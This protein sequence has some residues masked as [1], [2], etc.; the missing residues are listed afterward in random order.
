MNRTSFLTTM[1]AAALTGGNAPAQDQSVSP[2]QPG[3][4][5][6]KAAPP[7]FRH[8]VKTAAVTNAVVAVSPQQKEARAAFDKKLNDARAA[9]GKRDYSDAENALAQLVTD[10]SVGA[11]D[12]ARAKSVLVNSYQRQ[13]K[14]SEALK[15]NSEVLSEKA[16]AAKDRL[17]A[18]SVRIALLQRLD[19]FDEAA[20]TGFLLLAES[21]IKPDDALRFKKQIIDNYM[22]AGRLDYSIALNRELAGDASIALPER[23]NAFKGIADCHRKLGDLDQAIAVGNEA[24]ALP[25][26][27]DQK[28]AIRL[29]NAGFYMAMKP[30]KRAEADGILKGVLNDTSIAVTH[31]VSAYVAL[32]QPILGGGTKAEKKLVAELAKDIL[33]D[34]RITGDDFYRVQEQI[35]KAAKDLADTETLLAAASA[36]RARSDS[37]NTQKINATWVIVEHYMLTDRIAE[38][39]ELVREPLSYANLGPDDVITAYANIGRTLEWQEKCDEAVATY[40]EILTKANSGRAK[41]RVSQLIAGAL[42][43]FNRHEEAAQVYRDAGLPLEEAKVYR[44]SLTPEKAKPIALKV[45][46]NEQQPEDVRRQAY[47]FF[48]EPGKDDRQI[49][50]KHLAFYMKNFSPGANAGSFWSQARNAMMSANYE[51]ALRCLEIARTTTA[52]KDDFLAVLYQVNALA[53]L[54]RT[55]EAAKVAGDHA[56]SAKFTPEQRYQMALTAAM[57]QVGEQPGEIAKAFRAVEAASADARHLDSK[58]RAD[59]ILKVGRTAMIANRSVA[60]KEIYSVY[61]NLFV[62]EPKKLYTVTFSETPISGL[63]A[64]EHLRVQPVKQLLDRQF[65]GDMD[66]LVTDVA[67]GDRGAGIGS[68]GAAK[69]IRFTELAAICDVNGI[70]FVFTVYDDRAREVEA[71][72]AGGGSCEG[73]IAPGQNQPYTCFLAD[74][75]SGEISTWPSTYNNERHRRIEKGSSAIRSELAFTDEGYKTYMFLAWDSFYD[76]LPEAGDLWDFEVLHWSRSVRYSWN[77]T[78]SIHG[79]STWGNLQ[80][81]IPRKGML[82]IKRRQIFKACAK[83]KAEKSTDG[84]HQGVIDFWKDAAVGDAQFYQEAVAPYVETLD[85]FVPLVKVDMSDADVELVFRQAVPGWN[86]L[87]FKIAALRRQYL[88]KKLGE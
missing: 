17:N 21:D 41:S 1:L 57:L 69:K 67:T 47:E 19:R 84:K 49:A 2:S 31:R 77:G 3:A 5:T 68:E 25:L 46:E 81:N 30:A 79:R 43:Y 35:I 61:E 27:A 64:W 60:A 53:G 54:G 65:G 59:L 28:A 32:T 20:K 72:L 80:F 44:R 73:Y 55:A 8:V 88:E 26:D 71:K 37:S 9:I 6:V 56:A 10:T 45:L 48:M 36:I 22:R 18:L 14:T 66:F 82:D 75:Q 83:F 38:A 87:R 76:K 40:K 58:K 24:L 12:R 70:H 34:Q 63:A 52:Y 42:V 74:L 62:P 7:S 33:A 23:L 51:Y 29:R 4:G 50:E 16:L 15:L 39:E 78:K 85:A 13:E 86:E 11:A